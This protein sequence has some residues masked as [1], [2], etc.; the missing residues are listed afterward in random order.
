M[1]SPLPLRR[2]AVLWLAIPALPLLVIVAQLS[3]GGSAVSGYWTWTVAHSV[4]LILVPAALAAV[5]AA[6]EAS[7]L[8]TRREANATNVRPAA[9]VIVTALWPS[10]LAAL[11]LQAA[12]ITLVALSAPGGSSSVPWPMIATIAAMLLL[13]TC[14]GFTAASFMRPIVGIPLALTVSYCWLGFTGAI[15]AFA[16]RHLAG[17]VIETCC[18]Y[19]EQPI[20]ASLAAAG[21]FSVV[22][23]VGL[24]GI[25]S[26][27]LR[28]TALRPATVLAPG[29]LVA[30]AFAS[31]IGFAQGLES[32][33]A[34][35]RP[36][37][38]LVC[39]GANP[40]VCLFP[41]Q[42]GGDVVERVK[43]MVGKVERA[44]VALPDAVSATLDAENAIPFRYAPG[45]T[46]EQ[47]AASLASAFF[48]IPCPQDAE[49]RMIARQDA[50][51]LARAWLES[52]MSA[53]AASASVPVDRPEGLATLSQKSD[54]SQARWMNSALA[55][56]RDCAVDPPGLP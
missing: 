22:A 41:E 34:E 33:A 46:D 12:A 2:L 36:A 50:A 15:D 11:L 56:M 9:R 14:L 53:H 54:E 8:R 39:A 18:F 19:D 47:I 48:D 27:G 32:T 16:P 49:A 23:S 40:S 4:L 29:L 51:D 28:L 5:G 13:H 21:V 31:G 37:A 35:P 26:L 17:L 55:A 20:P 10:Y 42:L 3:G 43:V 45:M 52:T 24:L 7:R 38:Q 25:A 6:I 30:A 1:R 44:G